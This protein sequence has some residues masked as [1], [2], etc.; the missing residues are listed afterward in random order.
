MIAQLLRDLGYRVLPCATFK[1]V[2]DTVNALVEPPIGV[3]LDL[4]IAPDVKSKESLECG[5]DCGIWLRTQQHT[6]DV[7][8]I[9]YTGFD[10]DI[11][12]PGWCDVFDAKAMIKKKK[13][14]IKDIADVIRTHFR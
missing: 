4:G 1:H 9:A 13:D 5:R 8:I 3:L 14:T 11:R 7:P 2:K 10:E 6:R 12:I